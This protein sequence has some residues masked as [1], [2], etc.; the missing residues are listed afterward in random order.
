MR[1][2]PAAPATQPSPNS[3]TRLTS[4]RN[5]TRVA[6]RASKVGTASPVTVVEKTIST[7]AGLTLA[8]SNA[9]SSARS[10][11][12]RAVSMKMSFGFGEAAQFAVL[13]QRQR[14]AA[15]L[16]AGAGPEPVEL[17]P[18]EAGQAR[19][20]FPLADLMR[21]EFDGYR[22]DGR[23]WLWCWRSPCSPGVTG[24]ISQSYPCGQSRLSRFA[25]QSNYWNQRTAYWK[26]PTRQGSGDRAAETPVSAC[27][28]LHR[29]L[30]N[31]R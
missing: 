28:N 26:L 13:R 6:S 21:R 27:Q 8:A 1:A 20:C 4:G 22:R 31:R 25:G 18:A 11:S 24:R 10:P 15:G 30:E 2:T 19:Q 7:S 9:E 12:S 16:H 23:G 14:D 29:P 5:P 3:G 17:R